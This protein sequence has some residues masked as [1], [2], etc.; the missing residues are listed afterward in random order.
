MH[1]VRYRPTGGPVRVGV[2]RG[3]RVL[4]VAEVVLRQPLLDHA[5]KVRADPAVFVCPAELPA[6]SVREL[7]RRAQAV[8]R[9]LG[10]GERAPSC[11]GFRCDDAGEP[12]CLEVDAC[13]DLRPAGPLARA[14]RAAGR[15]YPDLVAWIMDLAVAPANAFTRRWE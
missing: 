10:L 9:A 11:V 4:P 8:H 3:D 15:T 7:T 1:L 13:P 2:R 14:A 6:A 12:Q 5:A